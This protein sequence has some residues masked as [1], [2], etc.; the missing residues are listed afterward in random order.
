METKQDKFLSSMLKLENEQREF[1]IQCL[2]R[3][4][5]EMQR[6]RLMRQVTH[7]SVGLAPPGPMGPPQPQPGPIAPPPPDQITEQQ[8][9]QLELLQRQNEPPAPFGPQLPATFGPA[10]GLYGPQAGQQ[11]PQGPIAPSPRFQPIQS[12]GSAPVQVAHTDVSAS[13]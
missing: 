12:S 2:K 4:I 1:L 10:Q 8:Q 3:D 6:T 5:E 7:K 11:Q 9:V 13:E